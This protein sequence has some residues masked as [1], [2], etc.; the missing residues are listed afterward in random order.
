MAKTLLQVLSLFQASDDLSVSS[1]RCSMSRTLQTD[2]IHTER[3][4]VNVQVICHSSSFRGS[5]QKMLR[6]MH[7]FQI[8]GVKTNIPFLDNLLR[9]PDF[10]A[11]KA[12]TSFIGQN[13]QLFDFGPQ[14]VVEASKLLNFLA[15]M[16]SSTPNTM[17]QVINGL[18]V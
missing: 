17:V 8:R 6:A 2:D 11:G 4:R 14:D 18:S 7:E 12:T 15:E 16:V 5:I 9:H 10:V 13:P 3:A 1:C